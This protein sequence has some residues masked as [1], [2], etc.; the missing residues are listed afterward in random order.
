M[1]A[2]PA[3]LRTRIVAAVEGGLAPREVAR[4]FAVSERTIRRYRTQQRQT[5]DLTPKRS[6]GRTPRI[7]A[8]CADRLRAQVAAQPDATLAQHCAVWKQEHGV[9]VSIATMSRALRR[10]A[11]TVKKSPV[12]RR[13]R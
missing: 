11:I 5:R 6:P 2:Y 8:E 7:G 9:A 1:N 4:L 3:E 10:L 13:A 12:R